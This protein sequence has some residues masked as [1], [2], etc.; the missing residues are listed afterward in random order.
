MYAVEAQSLSRLF[1]TKGGT[2]TAL[3][4]IDLKMNCG[5]VLGLLGANGAGK[6]TFIKILATLLLPSDGQAKVYGFDVLKQP[7]QVRKVINL[8]SGGETPGYGILSV[9]E[10]LWF[11]SQIYGLSSTEANERINKLIHDMELEEYTS[12]RMH[13]L[14][15]GFR[16]RLNLARGFINEPKVLFLDEPTL[17]LDVINAKHMRQY[18]KQW[19]KSEKSHAVLL[20]THYMV[21]A[22][23]M[24]DRI[25][26]IYNGSI[27]TCGTPQFLKASLVK[28]TTVKIEV[29]DWSSRL[30]FS[31]LKGIL[32]S[33]IQE[34]NGGVKKIIAVLDNESRI[35][36]LV[37][38]LAKG[39]CKII[40]INTSQPSLEDVYMKFVGKGIG[41][42]GHFK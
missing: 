28:D 7:K 32:G 18:V 1:K 19:V 42:D 2:I 30:N 29:T 10:N 26:I 23:D 33:S 9:K 31:E 39:G 11:F 40:S 4:K 37:S 34:N 5:E 17:G 27:I 41:M 13:K 20:T 16:Q 3:N 14:S 8:V 35:P 25:A 12:T 36:D 24:C 21:E 38:F 6:T 22:E 15:T